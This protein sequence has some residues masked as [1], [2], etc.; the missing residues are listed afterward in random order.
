MVEQPPSE[1]TGATAIVVR[2]PPKEQTMT[3]VAEPVYQTPPPTKSTLESTF[4]FYER[5]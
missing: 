1:I 5:F 4:K 2:S 3:A